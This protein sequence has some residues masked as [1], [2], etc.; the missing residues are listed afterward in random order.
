MKFIQYLNEKYLTTGRG[1]YSKGYEIFLNPSAKEM[2][3]AV[4]GDGYVRYLLVVKEKKVYIWNYNLTHVDA[5]PTLEQEGYISNGAYYP[6]RKGFIW[7]V[8]H[9]KSGK[10]VDSPED[11]YTVN[12]IK[13][14]KLD[15]T[16]ESWTTTYFNTD[17]FASMKQS[18]SEEYL[19]SLKRRDDPYSIYKNP[20]TSDFKALAKE[21]RIAGNNNLTIRFI[22]DLNNRNI[23]IW[24]ATMELHQNMENYLRRHDNLSPVVAYETAAIINN[25][26]DCP[27]MVVFIR[28]RSPVLDWVKPYFV[29]SE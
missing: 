11:E 20:T 18:I 21:M 13:Y 14:H 6:G 24:D 5:A 12:F 15:K 8:A 9:V 4:D 23:Y 26:I 2:K 17:L 25:K 3:E 28:K 29:V 7:G 27:E 1:F 16:K 10:L 19:I 22:I